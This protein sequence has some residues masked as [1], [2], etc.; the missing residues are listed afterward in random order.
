MVD[1]FGNYLIQKMFEVASYEELLSLVNVIAPCL[2][3][4]S[5]NVHG[6]RAVQTLIDVLS[7]N[8]KAN[9]YILLNI[10]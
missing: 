2:V 7:K 5:M 9:E 1:Q 10:I 8:T 4:I 3:E 6:T